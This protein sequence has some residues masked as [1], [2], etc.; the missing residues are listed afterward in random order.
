M[1][2]S[3]DRCMVPTLALY[4]ACHLYSIQGGVNVQRE[5]HLN[6]CRQWQTDL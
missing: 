6:N 1:G 2:Y 5:N 4:G 3:V